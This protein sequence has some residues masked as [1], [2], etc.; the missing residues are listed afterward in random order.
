M[1]GQ[2][3]LKIFLDDACAQ[4]YPS[5]VTELGISWS[6]KQYVYAMAA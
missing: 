5:M 3:P 6:R 2:K 1:D 4:Y